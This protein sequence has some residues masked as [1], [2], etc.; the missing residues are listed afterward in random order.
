ML[1]IQD[2]TELPDCLSLW[3]QAKKTV[4][5]SHVIFNSR[6]IAKPLYKMYL[7]TKEN[8][9]FSRFWFVPFGLC[10]FLLFLPRIYL[11]CVKK[12][13]E[14]KETCLFLLFFLIVFTIKAWL[15][16][17]DLVPDW[18]WN[19]M[20]LVFFEWSPQKIAAY[21]LTSKSPKFFF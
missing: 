5:K 13:H 8:V 15:C 7:Q 2:H 18:K 10:I 11:N 9:S 21:L 20:T 4:L 17:L 6:P 14:K 3:M 12:F 16:L 19:I 1:R